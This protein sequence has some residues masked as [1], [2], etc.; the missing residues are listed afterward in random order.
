MTDT[1]RL[2]DERWLEDELCRSEGALLRYILGEQFIASPHTVYRQLPITGAGIADIVVTIPD[3]CALAIIELKRTADEAAI[4]QCLRYKGALKH[5]LAQKGLQPGIVGIVM[6]YE[7]TAGAFYAA[8]T[9]HGFYIARVPLGREASIFS[10]GD[11]LK[12]VPSGIQPPQAL[13]SE[14]SQWAGIQDV[15]PPVVAP[16]LPAGSA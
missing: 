11:A 14:L 3:D 8:S 15:A 6:A 13:F 4:A 12:C 16:T 9:L 2:P 5:S 1:A 7:V 10:W